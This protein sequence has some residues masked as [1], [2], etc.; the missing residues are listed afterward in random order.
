MTRRIT[1]FFISVSLPALISPFMVKEEFIMCYSVFFLGSK[2]Y[3]AFSPTRPG[4]FTLWFEISQCSINGC[5]LFVGLPNSSGR[6]A[7]QL[8]K[9]YIIF[10]LSLKALYP[11]VNFDF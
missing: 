11:H 6:L 1:D 9:V 3:N 4:N 5:S 7:L 2:A 8:K 10:R